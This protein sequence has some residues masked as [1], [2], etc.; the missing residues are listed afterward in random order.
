MNTYTVMRP[1]ESGH[2]QG[3]GY[4]CGVCCLEG[5]LFGEPHFRSGISGDSTTVCE[6]P[7]PETF[8]DGHPQAVF[9]GKEI[10]ARSKPGPGQGHLLERFD[11]TAWTYDDLQPK[12]PTYAEASAVLNASVHD[13]TLSE[14]TVT[15]RDVQDG[16]AE[17]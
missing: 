5:L 4:K 7:V 11:G 13:D 12:I 17:E 16:S 1:H 15:V 2:P 9:R 3:G 10:A 8:A 6:P 14:T